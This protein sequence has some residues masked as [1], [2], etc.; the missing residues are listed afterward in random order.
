MR[1]CAPLSDGELT[2]GDRL[3]RVAIGQSALS[4]HLARLRKYEVVATRRQSQVVYYRIANDETMAT[5]Q[6]L[7][8][9]ACGER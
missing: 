9:L 7:L 4:Q 1:F 8:R 6:A 3:E 5:A 2:V